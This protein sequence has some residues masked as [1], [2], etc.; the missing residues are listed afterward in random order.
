MRSRAGR[1]EFRAE[2]LM[3]VPFLAVVFGLLVYLFVVLLPK[4]RVLPG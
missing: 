1:G 2:T 3:L 4:V